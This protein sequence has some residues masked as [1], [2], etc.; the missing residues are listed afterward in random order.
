MV[1][2]GGRLRL[3][4]R[5]P[6]SLITPVYYRRIPCLLLARQVITQPRLPAHDP[7]VVIG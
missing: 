7:G 5:A 6:L 2:G 1:M 4:I 3:T